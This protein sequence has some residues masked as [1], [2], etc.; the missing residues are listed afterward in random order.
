[1]TYTTQSNASVGT[2]KVFEIGYLGHEIKVNVCKT[3]DGYTASYI[4]GEFRVIRRIVRKGRIEWRAQLREGAPAV[5]LG[6]DLG[7]SSILSLACTG[8]SE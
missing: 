1:M 3:Y 4:T 5:F 8:F 7:M 6:F 2:R